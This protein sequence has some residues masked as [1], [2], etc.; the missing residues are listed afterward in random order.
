M[1]ALVLLLTLTSTLVLRSGDR[2]AAED[3]REANGVVTFR[4][5]GLLYSM[6]AEEIARIDSGAP[7]PETRAAQQAGSVRKLRVAEEDRKRLL[8]ALAQNHEGTP[9]PPQQVVPPAPVATREEIA[10]QTRDEW[11]WRREARAYEENVRQAKEELQLL[12]EREEQLDSEIRF[13]L[14]QG[15]KPRQFTYQTTQLAHT[16]EQIPYA[17]LAVTRAVRAYEQFRED[18]RR[19]GVM[20]GWLR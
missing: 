14:N 3:V 2:I 19:Q 8:D 11:S 1:N 10:Q 20:P 7:R 15:Y 12:L 6:P 5:G 9:A 16:R 13:F 4:S 18:A 17:E